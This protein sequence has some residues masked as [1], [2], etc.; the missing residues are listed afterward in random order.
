VTAGPGFEA[1]RQIEYENFLRD[2]PAA[3]ASV[4]KW[5]ADPRRERWCDDWLCGESLL[6]LLRL[7]RVEEAAGYH[8]QSWKTIRPGNGYQWFWGP[9][10]SFLAL[11][12]NLDRGVRLFQSMLPAAFDQADRLSQLHFLEH[13]LVLFRRL[14]AVRTKAVR[15]RVPPSLSWHDPGGR[16]APSAVLGWIEETATDI[17]RKFDER[18]GNGY[19]AELLEYRRGMVQAVRPYPLGKA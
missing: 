17:A 12:D 15:L 9:H 4:R 14:A 13:A 16:Y 1:G 8:R 18:N 11:T 6:P 3:A 5:F 10:L 2:D 7:G 19:H